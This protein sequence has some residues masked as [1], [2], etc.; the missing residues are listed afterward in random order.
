M[1]TTM[2]SSLSVK[3]DRYAWTLQH[4]REFH[5]LVLHLEDFVIVL[6]AAGLLPVES[7]SVKMLGRWEG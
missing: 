7:Q 3:I 5:L 4:A 1:R 6:S 2:S